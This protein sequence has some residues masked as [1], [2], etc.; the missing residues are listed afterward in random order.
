MSP[1]D[2]FVLPARAGL[3][4]METKPSARAMSNS[5]RVMVFPSELPTRH[6]PGQ[7]VNALGVLPPAGIRCPSLHVGERPHGFAAS[8]L[9]PA[10]ATPAIL[11]VRQPGVFVSGERALDPKT[12]SPGG[13]SRRG[14][15]YIDWRAIQPVLSSRG[16]DAVGSRRC[17]LPRRRTSAAGRGLSRE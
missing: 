9:K 11:P 3:P 6:R 1:A 14:P 12:L 15:Y 13:G 4:I 16:A 2:P 7:G 10:P 17:P 5:C 8:G